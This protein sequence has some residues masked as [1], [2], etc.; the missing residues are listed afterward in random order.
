MTGKFLPWWLPLFSFGMNSLVAFS[1]VRHARPELVC[2][3]VVCFAS[4][5]LLWFKTPSEG[6]MPARVLLGVALI[7]TAAVTFTVF[8]KETWLAGEGMAFGGPMLVLSTIATQRS[9]HIVP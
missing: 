3:P 7:H 2:I 6:P 5:V 1:M 4:V 8:A 9:R